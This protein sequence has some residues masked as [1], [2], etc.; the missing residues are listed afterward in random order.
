M[1]SNSG[2]LWIVATPLGNPGDFSPRARETVGA[3]DIVLAEDTRRTGL[4]LAA[5]EVKAKRFVSLHDHNEAGRIASIVEEL[6][7]GATAALV[8]D[9]GTPLVSDPGYLLVKACREAGVKVAPVPGPSAPL[10]ALSASGLPPLPFVFLGFA[11]RNTGDTRKFF[12]PYAALAATLIFFDRKDRVFAT[13]QTAKEILGNR[14]VCIARELTKTHEEYITCDL[15]TLPLER[16]LLGEITVVVGPPLANA[17]L[18]KAEIMAKVRFHRDLAP[19]AKPKEIARR[20]Q[21]ET[22]GVSAKT[23]YALMQDPEA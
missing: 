21:Q 8:S 5:C 11:P 9:A 10:A 14:A 7:A 22:P 23:I 12:A 4:L 2:T 16:E 1:S 17:T 6:L 3:A 15:E 20:V 19:D 18:S 13:L